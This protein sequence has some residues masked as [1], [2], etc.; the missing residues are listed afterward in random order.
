MINKILF[1]DHDSIDAM[2]IYAKFGHDRL[3]NVEDNGHSMTVLRRLVPRSK[4]EPPS[5]SLLLFSRDFCSKI[6]GRRLVQYSL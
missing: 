5:I 6:G 3:R 1:T 4:G 2:Y